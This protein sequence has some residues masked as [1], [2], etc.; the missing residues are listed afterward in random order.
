LGTHR[1]DSG[2]RLGALTR[3]RMGWAS[4]PYLLPLIA[5]AVLAV[6]VAS[7]AWRRRGTPGAAA[8]TVLLL[9]AGWWAVGYLFELAVDGRATKIFWAKVEYLG[10]VTA[11]VAWLLFAVA[12]TGRA[13]WT[14]RRV[15]AALAVLPTITLIL[16]WTNGRHE[17]IWSKIEVVSTGP[18]RVLDITPGAWFWV[19][20]AY[21]YALLALGSGLVIAMVLR[22]PRLYRQQSGALVF[23]ILVPWAANMFYVFGL[24]PIPELD[25]TVY[26]LP[27]AGSLLAWDLYRFALLDVG[28]TMREATI[29]AAVPGNSVLLIDREHRVLDLNRAAQAMLGVPASRALG[30]KLDQLRPDILEVLSAHWDRDE[31]QVEALIDNGHGERE[32]DVTL[33]ALRDQRGR[34]GGYLLVLRDST[35][36]RQVERRLRFIA[37]AGEV[38]AGSLEYETTLAQLSRLAVPFL[39]DV[40]IVDILKGESIETLAVAH[41][42]PAAEGLIHELHRRFPLD[43]TSNTVVADVV[44]S[45]QPRLFESVSDAQ[46]A[47]VARS[48]EHL[49]MLRAL[50]YR[51]VMMVPLIAR[52][53]IL[54]SIRLALTTPDRVYSPDDLVVAAELARHAALALDN[55]R[56]YRAAQEA[57]RTRE[58]FLSIASHEMKTPLTSLKVGSQLMQ[59]VV[60][61]PNIDVGHAQRLAA[62]LYGE[63]GRLE[64][65]VLDLLDVSR[66]QRG[67]FEL[68]RESV[69][70]AAL[71][72][73]ACERYVHAP[74]RTAQHAVLLDA[75][76][77]VEGNLDPGR[78]DQVLT[79]LI[80]NALKYSPVGGTVRV[81]VRR[82][83]D[84]A[85]LIVEDEGVGIPPEEQEQLFQPFIR[86][87]D[88][89]RHAPGTGLG[90]YITEQ[91]VAMHSGSISVRSVVDEG[92]TFVVR[93]PLNG[94][95]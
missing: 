48:S 26:A 60:G 52:G 46:L 22:S 66:M 17:L 49:D 53:Q 75:P 55:A 7:Y 57:T 77:P 68:H 90:L 80:S 36:R 85:L 70:L 40:C 71:A 62:R 34:I 32:Y 81:S 8:L 30:R 39:A 64:A 78:L 88:A 5:T 15:V 10:I 76:E 87:R 89:Q 25:L 42:D 79:N 83:A 54:G 95:L 33:S 23:G 65:L 1:G 13:R 18:L 43:V 24:G 38:L 29:S 56:L 16:A 41:V 82:E 94:P 27:I 14:S 21:S 35:Q 92:S 51:A 44:R 93:L 37:E 72:R 4:L 3:N 31:A 86:G 19:N 9:A 47:D 58:E 6:T 73:R 67:A 69:D 74:E 63:A 84:E 2:A 50:G 11:P 12:Y 61:A 91:I 59:R 20:V 28:P 45:G